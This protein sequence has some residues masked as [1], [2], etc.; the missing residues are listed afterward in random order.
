MAHVEGKCLRVAAVGFDLARQAFE[1]FLVTG[2][3]RQLGAGLGQ[4]H[5]ARA[6]DPLRSSGYQCYAAFHSCHDASAK[7]S[8]II[9]SDW[10]EQ[11]RDCCIEVE[12][13]AFRLAFRG[14]PEK[15]LHSAALAAECKTEN[16]RAALTRR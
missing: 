12:E 16:Q 7:P 11:F 13:R 3:E 6:T 10:L 15:V 8:R 2:T 4:E 5:R 1:L 14:P 9:N